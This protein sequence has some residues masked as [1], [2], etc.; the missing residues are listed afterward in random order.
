MKK[1]KHEKI[2]TWKNQVLENMEEEWQKWRI[3]WYDMK[4][5]EGVVMWMNIMI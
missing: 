5:Y 4:W 2:K 1:S 3:L